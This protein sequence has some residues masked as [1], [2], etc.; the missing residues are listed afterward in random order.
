[1]AEWCERVEIA[2]RQHFGESYISRFHQGGSNEQDAR[3]MTIW[4]MNHRLETLATF[5]K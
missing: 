3:E 5:Q 4:K 1:M 2:L